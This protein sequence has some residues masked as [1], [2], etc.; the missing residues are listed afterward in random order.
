MR[1]QGPN[2]MDTLVQNTRDSF[3]DVLHIPNL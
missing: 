3:C 2:Y 1:Q